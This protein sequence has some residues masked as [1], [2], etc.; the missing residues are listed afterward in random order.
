MEYENR[1]YHYCARDVR[2]LGGL[3][4]WLALR[5]LPVVVA[6][7]VVLLLLSS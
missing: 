6:A 5:A 1:V 4:L 2:R 3:P 7:A